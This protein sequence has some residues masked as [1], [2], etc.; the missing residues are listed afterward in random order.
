[1]L[2]PLALLA[3]R[4]SFAQMRMRQLVGKRAGSEIH[5]GAPGYE[6]VKSK[7]VISLT[8]GSDAR[9]RVH[10][11]KNYKTLGIL[12]LATALV[13]SLAPTMALSQEAP[14]SSRPANR[15]HQYL[16]MTEAQNELRLMLASFRNDMIKGG[17]GYSK[18]SIRELP[19]SHGG[20]S[21]SFQLPKGAAF[22]AMVAAMTAFTKLGLQ[23][24]V[25]SALEGALHPA[26]SFVVNNPPTDDNNA[27]GNSSSVV[28]GDLSITFFSDKLSKDG[29]SVVAACYKAAHSIVDS[30]ASAF[31]QSPQLQ[32]GSQDNI[33]DQ[34]DSSCKRDAI[35]KLE[36][37]GLR[38]FNGGGNTSLNE[39][40][41][42]RLDWDNFAGYEDVKRKIDDTLI[43][44]LK[45]PDEYDRISQATR[46][47]FEMNRP[48]AILLEGPPGTGKTLTAR[49]VAGKCNL[50]MVLVN[51]EH[52]V[53]KWYGD[54]EKRLAEIWNACENM[55]GAVIFLDEVDALGN[56]RD[57]V[58]IYTCTVASYAHIYASSV[59][60]QRP[61]NQQ[62]LY[63]TAKT[64]AFC[65]SLPA[66]PR[67]FKKD[68]F[69]A[70]A[71]NRWF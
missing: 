50:P 32:Q 4:R 48:R 29:L 2:S 44:P 18:V 7:G 11:N 33:K 42:G 41:N 25:H 27:K 43:L 35:A 70:F 38:V 12:A 46:A 64:C 17:R 56:S 59:C 40:Q 37:M 14:P 5:W 1:M 21:V 65:F 47:R 23:V 49:I 71:K 20:Y 54:S 13:A 57:K 58:Y 8:I 53:S 22:Y 10:R 55:G 19:G 16:E 34:D 3:A 51:I 66:T 69:S 62:H 6:A 68:S 30:R 67:S 39:E 24:E 15:N 9:R 45:H 63:M 26:I 28:L 36:S 52:V 31:Q 61:R 60:E